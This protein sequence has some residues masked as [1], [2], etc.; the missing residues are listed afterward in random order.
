MTSKLRKKLQTTIRRTTVDLTRKAALGFVCLALTLSCSN[1]SAQSWTSSA[2]A[3]QNP[4]EFVPLSEVGSGSQTTSADGTGSSN[5]QPQV[6][7]RTST[8]PT[9]KTLKWVSTTSPEARDIHRSSTSAPAQATT[10]A[11]KKTAYPL[12]KGYVRLA[13]GE[14]NAHLLLRDGARSQVRHA[15]FNDGGDAGGALPPALP[16]ATG[17]LSELPTDFTIPESID[18]P[19]DAGVDTLDLGIGDD[20]ETSEALAPPVPDDLP[21]GEV[22][23]MEMLE[24]PT[25]RRTDAQIPGAIGNTQNQDLGSETGASDNSESGTSGLRRQLPEPS[26]RSEPD[27]LAPPANLDGGPDTSRWDRTPAGVALDN[28]CPRP[29]DMKPINEITN[30][31]TPPG[32]FFPTDC[33]LAQKDEN[34]PARQF[35]GTNVTW[36]ASNLCHNP[37]YFEQPALERY[38][39]TIGPL[40]PVLSGAQFLI[41]IPALPYLMAMDPVNECQYPLGYYRP[42]SCAPYKWNPLPVSVRGAI[43]E[44]GVA[45]ALVFL[46]P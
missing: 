41:T 2:G 40:Q 17:G 39:H 22:G 45:T 5:S 10:Q 33:P 19:A 3:I 43:M 1:A 34:F 26:I 20:A 27:D 7:Y 30:D 37:L 44:G 38:G 21:L 14:E 31:I 28:S 36:T 6:A 16:D 42:G 35:A 29:K 11:E 23:G 8:S 25:P 9:G 12:K 4:T 15:A 32:G 46:I 24:T 13:S 18:E